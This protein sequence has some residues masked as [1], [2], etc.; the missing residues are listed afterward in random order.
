[1]TLTRPAPLTQAEELEL[2]L[3]AGF[4]HVLVVDSTHGR[5]SV[6]CDGCQLVSAGHRLLSE[7]LGSLFDEPP[8]RATS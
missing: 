7:A 6:R 3:A 1:M 5:W 4:Q 8:P 2:E